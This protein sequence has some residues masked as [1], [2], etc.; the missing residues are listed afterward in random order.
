LIDKRTCREEG[1]RTPSAEKKSR[2]SL[3]LMREGSLYSA[4]K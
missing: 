1:E 2:E 4:F 3:F